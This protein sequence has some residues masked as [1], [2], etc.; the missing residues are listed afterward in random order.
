[1]DI[2]PYV[3]KTRHRVLT[4]LSNTL[5]ANIRVNA[6]VCVGCLCVEEGGGGG[7]VFSLVWSVCFDNCHLVMYGHGNPCDL[8][9]EPPYQEIKYS[10]SEPGLKNDN[11]MTFPCSQCL[12]RN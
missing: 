4:M 3:S 12:S 11:N 5:K 8:Y 2:I 1:M 10:N 6:L 9:I 7:I